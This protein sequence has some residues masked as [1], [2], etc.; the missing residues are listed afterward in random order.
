MQVDER[1]KLAYMIA[2]RLSHF[3]TKG[4]ITTEIIGHTT[5][6]EIITDV[7]GRD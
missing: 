5:T 4:E 6:G 2:D 1:Y 3:L 7:I